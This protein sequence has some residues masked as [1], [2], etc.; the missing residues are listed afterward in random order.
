MIITL[1][2]N[3]AVL[4]LAF[5][6]VRRY[7][8]SE[9]ISYRFLSLAIIF[10]AQIIVVLLFWGIIGRLYLVNVV[11]SCIVIFS[12]A[13]LFLHK[14]RIDFDFFKIPAEITTNRAAIFC[15]SFL[16]GFALIKI[17]I[18]LVNPPFGWDN[19]NY[20]F[21]FPVEW[22]KH[23]NLN[24]P[25]TINDDLGPSYYPINGS[26]IYLWFILPLKN[27]FL[28]DL[29]QAPF[30]L[31]SFVA[32][33]GI[34][35]HFKINKEYSFYAAS[36]FTITPN[37]FK[38]MEVA[39]VDVMV[40]A[41]FLAGLYFLV[42][43][44]NQ[45][46]IVNVALFAISCG[47]LIG[48]KT[49]ALAYSL[50]L[51]AL[52]ILVLLKYYRVLGLK[53]FILYLALFVILFLIFGGYGYI[54]NFIQ[55]GNPVYPIDL[56]FL[57]R[58]VFKGVYDRTFY[59]SHVNASDYA[60]S[61][62]LFH[63]GM[64]V[65]LIL[66]LIP[67]F[68][69]FSFNLFRNYSLDKFLIFLIPPMLFLI[70]RYVIPLANLRYLYPALAVG[71]IAS[72]YMLSKS[73]YK[74]V[75]KILILISILASCAE[76]SNGL[77]L[78]FSFLFSIMIF[79]FRNRFYSFLKNAYR[80]R[81]LTI[82]AVIAALYLLNID[83]NRNEYRRYVKMEDYSGFWPD[84]T[85]AWL[86]LNDNTSGNNIAYV[87]RPVPFPLYGTNFKNNVFY[88]SVNETDPAMIHYFSR[89]RYKWGSDFLELHRNL[90]ADGNY[91]E[92]SDYKV[93][94]SNLKRRETAYL[95]I[96]SFH[97][98]KEIVFPIEEQWAKSNPDLFLP[99]FSNS[100]INIYKIR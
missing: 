35:R 27:V 97:Q 66:F 86:W 44:Y 13:Y 89:S 37:Y 47:M 50:L 39:Y 25:I 95:F 32:L 17:A 71:Y 54:R 87:G 41:W 99:V 88:V 45:K 7:F 92:R 68:L 75:F 55:T 57:G 74:V 24:N 43:F 42:S 69:Y 53:K 83:Y 72:S 30:F 76:I 82:L 31:I 5:S 84:A 33:Y 93:W 40:C 38:Q 85:R 36:L 19:L 23:A 100:T 52:F 48:T 46:K 60:V 59:T 11:L 18:N 49:I 14:K 29:A 12:V 6:I 22:L 77:E 1:F 73:R 34:C 21:T 62:I 80:Y 15:L 67:G 98:T 90:E 91:R 65:G 26:L 20:H 4:S 56:K 78:V 70:W 64:G 9:S 2:L 28:A 94:L 61:K 79:L 81:I 3:I 51:I 96:Y 10:Y 16:L 58:D 63:E 8:V